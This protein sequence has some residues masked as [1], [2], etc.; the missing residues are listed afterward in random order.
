MLQ[1]PS[2]LLFYELVDHITQ[3]RPNGVKPLVCGADIVQAIVIKEYLLYNEYSNRFAEFRASL[4]DPKAEWDYLCREEEVND[5]R[6]VVLDERPNN[7]Q[8]C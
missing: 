8:R 1:K 5:F 4:H 3:N 7:A 6:R 2:S